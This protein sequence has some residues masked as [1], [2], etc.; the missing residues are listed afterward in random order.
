MKFYY[1]YILKSVKDNKLYIGKTTNLVE[2]MK[3]HNRG[4]VKATKARRPLK[5]IFYEAF[6]HKTDAGR[7]ELFFKSG[8]GREVLGE[9][10]KYSKQG[11][12]A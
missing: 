11:G 4:E 3:K 12:I 5:L 2:R 10:L 6:C 7:D 1:V 8:Y 9:K